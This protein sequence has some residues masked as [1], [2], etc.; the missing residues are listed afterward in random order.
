MK[1]KC[2]D[3]GIVKNGCKEIVMV[4]NKTWKR[5]L[6]EMICRSCNNLTEEYS[7]CLHNNAVENMD[8]KTAFCL[9]C[10]KALTR[11]RWA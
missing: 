11:R 6:G 2:F 9:D 1:A 7:S 3:C 10:G 5:F 4:E 8:G